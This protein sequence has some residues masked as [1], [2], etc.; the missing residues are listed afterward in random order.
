MIQ[1]F[2]A[3]LTS[4]QWQAKHFRHW[5]ARHHILRVSQ[6]DSRRTTVINNY[7]LPWTVTGLSL[8]MVIL[9]I[10][11]DHHITNTKNA[12]FTA[13]P[14][15][16]PCICVGLSPQNGQSND[17]WSTFTEISKTMAETGCTIL[18][19]PAWTVSKMLKTTQ[20]CSTGKLILYP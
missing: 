17:P 4:G 12:L 1:R 16:W 13:N 9:L 19:S 11:R 20:E 7:T 14:A 6:H 8:G 5:R 18:F 2:E 10:Y 3:L 15:K